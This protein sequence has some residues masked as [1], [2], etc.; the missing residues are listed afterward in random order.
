LTQRSLVIDADGNVRA[1]YSDVLP[2]RELGKISVERAS[3]VEFDPERQVWTATEVA[4][5]A[6]IGEGE[7]REGVIAQE[8]AMLEKKL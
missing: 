5:G 4:T 6:T 7:S 1:V 3:T 8:I 2:L